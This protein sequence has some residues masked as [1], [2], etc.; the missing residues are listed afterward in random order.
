MNEKIKEIAKQAG[1]EIY[2]HPDF[3]TIIVN[4]KDADVLIKNFAELIVK[5]CEN[6]LLERSEILEK[7]SGY[8]TQ[9]CIGIKM[10]VNIIKEHFK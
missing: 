7:M 10:A 6:V 4:G 2:G 9:E 3:V 5:E 1:A 8:V